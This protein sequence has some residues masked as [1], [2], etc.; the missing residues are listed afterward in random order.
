MSAIPSATAPLAPSSL[1]EHLFPL[2][3]FYAQA[4]MALP[5]IDVIAGDQLPEPYRRLLYHNHDMTPTLEDYYGCDI[6]LEILRRRQEG[7]FYFREVVLRLDGANTPVEFGANKISLERFSPDVRQLILAEHLPLGHILKVHEVPHS[8]RPQAYFRVHSDV[9]MS[10]SLGL[11][12]PQ[13]IY[14]RRNTLRDPQG[15][16]MSEIV[17]ILAPPPRAPAPARA[18]G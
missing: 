7:E 9:F 3:E 18:A 15:R 10:R 13:V 5:P 4:G 2:D 6:H 8:S 14:G 1:G 11:A 12:E 16:P 17:E